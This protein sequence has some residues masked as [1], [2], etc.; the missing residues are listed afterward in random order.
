MIPGRTPV[1]ITYIV[2][3]SDRSTLPKLSPIMAF[4][5]WLIAVVAAPSV[6]DEFVWRAR[7]VVVGN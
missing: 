1:N 7:Q 5:T 4:S 2:F 3:F 6:I